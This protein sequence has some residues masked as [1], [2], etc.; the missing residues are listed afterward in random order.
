MRK[1]L[2]EFGILG[3]AVALG[4]VV[5]GCSP[6]MEQHGNLLEDRRLE[7]IQV[8][9]STS[10]DVLEALGTP[11]SVATFDPRL[12]YYIGQRTEQVSFF[13]PEVVERRVVAVRFNDGGVVEEVRQLGA[14]DAQD[15]EIVDRATPTLGRQMT[16]LE[17]LVGNIGRFRGSSQRGTLGR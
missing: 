2:K 11:S 7:Q 1:T 13:A 10:Q 8:G 14:D 9:Q 15:V 5:A 16:V 17:Q 4:A 6:T 3:A 12:W